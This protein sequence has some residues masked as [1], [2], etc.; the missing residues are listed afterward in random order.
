MLTH[1]L[2]NYLHDGNDKCQCFATACGCRH[3]NITWPIMSWLAVGCQKPWDHLSLNWT[4]E[5]IKYTEFRQSYV[6]L[7]INGFLDG[8]HHSIFNKEHNILQ[9]WSVPTL[10]WKGAEE[11]PTWLD[12]K[13]TMDRQGDGTAC[14]G[15]GFR[16]AVCGTHRFGTLSLITVY[17]VYW[18]H[19]LCTLILLND[20][21]QL[22]CYPN[23]HFY[24]SKFP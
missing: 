11:A 8:V 16:S 4:T 24:S 3:T 10:K 15:I 13:E 23:L 19:N 9:T 20:H 22:T 14:S 1:C 7:S 21:M 12:L 5:Q 17:S 6:A 18:I 2:C